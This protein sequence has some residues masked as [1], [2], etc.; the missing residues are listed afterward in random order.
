MRPDTMAWI[1]LW[2]LELAPEPI[3]DRILHLQ[4]TSD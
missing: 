2:P 4:Y 1:M 3:R